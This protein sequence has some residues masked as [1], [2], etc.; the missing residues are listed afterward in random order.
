MA[1]MFSA[2]LM[3][4]EGEGTVCVSSLGFHNPVTWALVIAFADDKTK[5]K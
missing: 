1:E 2:V 5:V 4:E 3:A